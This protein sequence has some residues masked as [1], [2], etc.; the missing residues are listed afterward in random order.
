[1]KKAQNMSQKR[2]QKLYRGT[3]DR[4]HYFN[5]QSKPMRGGIRL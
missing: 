3:V 5:I 4:M 2:N 1:M